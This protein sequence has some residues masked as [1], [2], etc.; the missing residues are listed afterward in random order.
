MVD[1]GSNF[2]IHYLQIF[3]SLIFFFL[4]INC[5]FIHT[6]QILYHKHDISVPLKII[7]V[8]ANLS[9]T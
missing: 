7:I 4:S 9:D 2:N 3:L 6:D 5:I 8:L 1:T